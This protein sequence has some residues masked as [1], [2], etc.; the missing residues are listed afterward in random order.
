M[1]KILIAEDDRPIL[2]ALTM[3][4]EQDG[5]QVIGHLDGELLNSGQFEMPDIFLLDKQ[6][7]GRDG[8]LLCRQ[9]KD[10]PISSSIPVVIISAAAFVEPQANL[11]GADA[12]IEKPFSSEQIRKLVETLI[13]QSDARRGAA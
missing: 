2:D 1:K 3:L 5:Y 10:N 9:L 4:F 12:F 7:S 8:L 6:L 11:A 13:G